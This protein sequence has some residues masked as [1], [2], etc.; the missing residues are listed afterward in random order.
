MN[1]IQIVKIRKIEP[2]NLC[3]N[4]KNK[5]KDDNFHVM[6]YMQKDYVYHSREDRDW[7]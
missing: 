3:N 5:F 1:N 7:G 4:I 2:I 6:S